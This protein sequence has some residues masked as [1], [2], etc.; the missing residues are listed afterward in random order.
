MN[1]FVLFVSNQISEAFGGGAGGM[2]YEQMQLQ[3]KIDAQKAN[4]KVK[5][6]RIF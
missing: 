4:N 5:K 2:R 6:S 1:E 3:T